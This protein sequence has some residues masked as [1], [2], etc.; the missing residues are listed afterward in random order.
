MTKI[1]IKTLV[2]GALC[3]DLQAHAGGPNTGSGGTNGVR[4]N[5][6]SLNGG[7]MNG[8]DV[9]ADK[10]GMPCQTGCAHRSLPS[11]SASKPLAQ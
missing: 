11:V 1:I 10:A 3:L 6:I 8:L 9:P 2:L 5:G 4:P 7:T